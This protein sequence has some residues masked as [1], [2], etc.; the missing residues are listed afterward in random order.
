[1]T[2][3]LLY[4][5]TGTGK[6]A[7]AMTAPGPILLLDT[8]GFSEQAH[9]YVNG[10]LQM[11]PL[12]AWEVDAPYIDS[13]AYITIRSLEDLELIV[14]R[15]T[16][17]PP[18][19]SSIV[20]NS[21]DDIQEMIKAKFTDSKGMLKLQDWGGV[22]QL[23][24]DLVRRL[25]AIPDTHIV[26]T[27]L[28]KERFDS[29]RIVPKLQG[30]FAQTIV[31][32]SHITAYIGLITDDDGVMVQKMKIGPKQDDTMKFYIKTN[33]PGM[34][35]KTGPVIDNPNLEALI[36]INKKEKK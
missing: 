31:E 36:N 20:I 25:K 10:E 14:S 19:V 13:D 27:C 8:Q 9:K 28:S 29:G 24:K 7:L 32:Q 23:G 5:E 1:M 30:Q 17:D 26:I 15:L 3:I 21:L 34:I 4:G 18:P 12:S 2:A 6:S 16:T 35:Q 11:I 22:S 33:I